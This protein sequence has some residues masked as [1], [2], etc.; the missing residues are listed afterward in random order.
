MDPGIELRPQTIPD[1]R[2][3]VTPPNVDPKMTIDP[4][5]AP[6]ARE[7]LNPNGPKQDL[8]GKPRTR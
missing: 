2:S 1:S 3:A 8:P 7:K 4:E 5:T 6:P